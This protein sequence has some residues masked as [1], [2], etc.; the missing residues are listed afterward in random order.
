M[1]TLIDEFGP[2]VKYTKRINNA[3]ADALSRLR[4]KT[5]NLVQ[6]LVQNSL[7]ALEEMLGMKPT[8]ELRMP[9]FLLD[10]RIIDQEQR[11]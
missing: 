3:V 2:K 10:A 8:T 6:D 4:T 5:G 7:E 11:K 9:L 1:A